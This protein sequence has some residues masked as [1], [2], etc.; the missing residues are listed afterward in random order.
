MPLT[1]VVIEEINRGQPAQIFG[2]MLTLLETDKRNPDSSLEL[3]YRRPDEKGVYVPDNLYVIGTMNI[4]DRSL[5]WLILH[6]ADDLPSSIW[7]PFL[8]SVGPA[9]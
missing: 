3:T 4:A 5:A 1:S 2:E 7:S 9:G 8:M 6:F